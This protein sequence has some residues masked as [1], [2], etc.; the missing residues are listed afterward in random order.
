MHSIGGA[1]N[2]PTSFFF[3]AA[4][5]LLE[6]RE[7]FALLLHQEDPRVARV[8]IDE[9]GVVAA[10]AERRRLS[11]SPY[12]RVYYVVVKKTI[13]RR[14]QCTTCV[15]RPLHVGTLLLYNN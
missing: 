10:S 11:R 1:S 9:G 12:V 6:V 15:N 7:H 4:L 2:V 13:P 14:K 3:D 5:E 8:V